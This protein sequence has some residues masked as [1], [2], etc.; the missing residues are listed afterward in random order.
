MYV[1]MAF[2]ALITAMVLCSRCK[3]LLLSASVRI[4]GY[5]SYSLLLDL[6]AKESRVLRYVKLSSCSYIAYKRLLNAFP[7][8]SGFACLLT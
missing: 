3:D 8:S 6:R 2:I 4:I 7:Q 5:M 1:R